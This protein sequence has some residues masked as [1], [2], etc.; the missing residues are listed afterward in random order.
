MGDRRVLFVCQGTGCVSSKSPEIQAVL[1]KEIKESGLEDVHVKLTGC[2]GF[3]QQGPIIIV[4]PDGIFYGLVG[5]DDIPEIVESHLV[6]D[7]QVERLFY[8]EPATGTPIPRYDDIPFYSKQTRIVLKDCGKI[9]SEEIDDY[10]EVDGY[11][12]LTKALTEMRPDDVIEEVKRSGLR[13]RG[14]AGF[15]TGLKW[16]F[17]R[18]A[19]GD[20]KYLI[21]NADEGDP[22][23]F[24][25]RSILE[26]TPHSVIEGMVIAGYAFGAN[27]GYIYV[28]TEYPL[29]IHRLRIA[30]DQAK[31]RGFLG[32]NIL[33]SG[34]GF[35][36][37]L[38][39]G[40][41][42]FVCGEE[43]ALMASIEGNRGMPRPR[44]PYPAQSGLF[45]KPTTINNVK[46][47]ALVSPIILNGAEWF[48]NIGTEKSKGTAVFAL[49]GKVANS[50]LIEVPMGTT[51]R[52][53]IYGIGGGILNNQ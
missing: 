25:D 26:A 40:A 35:E 41:G 3:C 42:A 6:N 14:G 8:K 16:Q 33:G 13:G 4:E 11:K 19:E 47:L 37:I 32:E 30:V 46:S 48:S 29:A 18:D 2:H 24:M 12:A 39:E 51:L 28:R 49:T 5:L 44:P 34:H 27:T 53:I 31:E 20:Q 43:T 21:C 45:D 50:G 22:G 9:N 1:E 23:A 17:C 38:F 15:P 10:I 7:K 36:L 52:E